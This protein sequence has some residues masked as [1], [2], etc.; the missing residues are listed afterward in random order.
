LAFQGKKALLTLARPEKRNA[1]SASM[2]L[3]LERCVVALE[4]WSGSV[5]ILRGAGGHFC[6]GADLNLLNG[7][8]SSQSGG[9]GMCKWMTDLLN[10]IYLAPF[11]SIAVVEGAAMGGGAELAIATDFRLMAENARIQFVQ[12]KR[13]LSP[14]WGGA[15][16]LVQ[17]AGR[18]RAL[19]L[20]ARAEPIAPQSALEC[21]LVDLVFGQNEADRALST[22]V[23]PILEHN[24]A[25]VRANKTAVVAACN[26]GLDSA[27]EKASFASVWPPVRTRSE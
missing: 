27:G 4:G 7:P 19:S 18:T 2:M 1:V 20:L 25:A 13:G 14:G 22:F 16:R 8:L 10:R 15:A 5:L 9:E 3:D 17:I 6:A 24:S 26:E 11:V 21:G 23:A 12:A